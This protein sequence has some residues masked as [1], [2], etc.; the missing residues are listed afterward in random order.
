MSRPRPRARA[1]RV[2]ITPEEALGGH[3][4][5]VT[6]MFGNKRCVWQTYRTENAAM[7]AADSLNVRENASPGGTPYEVARIEP[8]G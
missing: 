3:R 1:A 6:F 7:A 5:A 8:R 2:T 4:W